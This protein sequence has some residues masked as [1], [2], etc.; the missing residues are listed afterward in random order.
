MEG[1]AVNLGSITVA[2][3]NSPLS[4]ELTASF[5]IDS[6][7]TA[8][9]LNQLTATDLLQYSKDGN[10]W[11]AKSGSCQLVFKTFIN[12]QLPDP[13]VINP[14]IISSLIGMAAECS[15]WEEI[16]LQLRA[17]HLTLPFG[18]PEEDQKPETSYFLYHPD[19]S[20]E[21]IVPPTLTCV[22]F[23]GLACKV[24]LQIDTSW[25]RAGEAKRRSKK[26]NE[27][28][29]VE[30]E[31]PMVEES[32][33]DMRGNSRRI[34]RAANVKYTDTSQRLAK[35]ACPVTQ[36]DPANSDSDTVILLSISKE[37]EEEMTLFLDAALR[38]LS[39]TAHAQTSPAIANGIARLRNA[40]SSTLREKV[41]RLQGAEAEAVSSTLE[42]PYDPED[43]IRK[44]VEKRLWSLC[45][46]SIHVEPT[47]KIN[48]RKA[49]VDGEAPADTQA[50]EM[51]E[52]FT[53]LTDDGWVNHPPSFGHDYPFDLFDQ[54]TD[55]DTETDT[56]AV[57]YGYQY[58]LGNVALFED[59]AE[60]LPE[61]YSEEETYGEREVDFEGD[62]DGEDMELGELQPSSEGDYVYADGYGRLHPIPR[63][64]ALQA[65][66]IEGPTLT[67]DELPFGEEEDHEEFGDPEEYLEGYLEWGFA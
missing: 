28:P 59:H 60:W 15:L 63:D 20:S 58:Q 66:Q 55:T 67:S 25:R 21:M 17:K 10:L 61:D 33:P 65:C 1:T 23:K 64:Q 38:K 46:T 41:G 8:L 27:E 52:A 26:V 6:E 57:E 56:D 42:H 13:N 11:M 2:R 12:G 22:K 39:M 18:S 14:A 48:K 54:G 37:E 34:M 35:K 43:G 3:K 50:E 45:Q 24:N 51:M 44:E 53:Q 49:K 32:K 47:V 29:P 36:P 5:L 31:P 19:L 30:S 40:R 7:T 62:D 9:G 4:L 16:G